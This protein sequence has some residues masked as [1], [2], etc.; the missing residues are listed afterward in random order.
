MLE[1]E[2]KKRKSFSGGK[3]ERL[4]SSKETRGKDPVRWDEKRGFSPWGKQRR[5]R[6]ERRSFR[7]V[8][9]IGGNR[10]KIVPKGVPLGGKKN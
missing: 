7:G 2:K 9:K 10:G 5:L 6:E 1:E 4:G 3:K 8:R